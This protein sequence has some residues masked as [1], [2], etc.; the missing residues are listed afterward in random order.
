[1]TDQLAQLVAAVRNSPS[2]RADAV[3]AASTKLA[4]GE[5]FSPQAAADSALAMLL[6]VPPPPDLMPDS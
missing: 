6:N 1:M 5:L 2:V 4:S 3:D